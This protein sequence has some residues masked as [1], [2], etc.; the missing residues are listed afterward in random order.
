[1][2][3]EF[4]VVKMMNDDDVV[5]YRRKVVDWLIMRLG[6]PTFEHENER[7]VL[8]SETQ[9]E[10]W[11]VSACPIMGKYHNWSMHY[12]ITIDDDVIAV[13]FALVKDS[14]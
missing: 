8:S 12:F 2:A 7:M 9:S 1:M 14:L 4:Q 11:S 13:E 6:E 5:E 3:V 10:K